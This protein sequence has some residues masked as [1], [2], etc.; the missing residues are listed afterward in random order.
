MYTPGSIQKDT[1]YFVPN[2][3]TLWHVLRGCV[4]KGFVI[5]S[6]VGILAQDDN[7]AKELST[8]V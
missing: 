8:E 7:V 5:G 6:D 1:L 4:E 2:D 3:S